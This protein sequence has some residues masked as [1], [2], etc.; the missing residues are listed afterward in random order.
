VKFQSALKTVKNSK[1]GNKKY[2]A[3]KKTNQII[4]V[5]D[6]LVKTKPKKALNLIKKNNAT[7]QQKNLYYG[8]FQFGSVGMYNTYI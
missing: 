1:V 5:S 8:D 4:D 7:K 2:V 3:N 6:N